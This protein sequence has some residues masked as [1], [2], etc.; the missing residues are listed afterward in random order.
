MPVY[1]DTIISSRKRFRLYELYFVNLFNYYCKFY[2]QILLKIYV[3]LKNN[4]RQLKNIVV[5]D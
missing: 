1:I 3:L 5:E 2:H 4:K